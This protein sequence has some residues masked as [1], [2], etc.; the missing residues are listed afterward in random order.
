MTGSEK[1]DKK[2][3]LRF[4]LQDFDKKKSESNRNIIKETL[5]SVIRLRVF[6]RT[7][8]VKW[9]LDFISIEAFDL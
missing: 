8:G 7:L 4:F 2:I 9:A 5:V 3:K 1:T 6:C